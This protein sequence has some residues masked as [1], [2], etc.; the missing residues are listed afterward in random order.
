MKFSVRAVDV[1][2]HLEI[3]KNH[4]CDY[5]EAGVYGLSAEQQVV[6][7]DG[8]LASPYKV[9]VSV[10]NE[11]GHD[12]EGI[13]LLAIGGDGAAGAECPAGSD[14]RFYLPALCMEVTAGISLGRLIVNSLGFVRV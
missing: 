13:V 12:F 10:K 9:K 3:V 7:G 11:S 6:E 14:S 2:R 5:D 4:S 8:S 1:A